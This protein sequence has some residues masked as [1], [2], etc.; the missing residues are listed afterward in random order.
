[1][2]KKSV[3]VF[4]AALRDLGVNQV[5]G[6]CIAFL[7]TWDERPPGL[8][9]LMAVDE[10][11]KDDVTLFLSLLFLDAYCVGEELGTVAQWGLE[12]LL[13]R[14]QQPEVDHSLVM[15][16]KLVDRAWVSVRGSFIA[17]FQGKQRGFDLA[18]R[19]VRVILQTTT[20]G[21]ANRS[22]STDLLPLWLNLAIR[23]NSNSTLL[24]VLPLFYAVDEEE[25]VGP[26][27]ET[28]SS[29]VGGLGLFCR[30]AGVLGAERWK[31]LL[32]KQVERDQ[33]SRPCKMATD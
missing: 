33:L 20:A 15:V 19:I 31:L 16:A 26:L 4:A 10:Q 8:L 28:I 9:E 1:M 32:S 25:P 12:R 7:R 22:I 24:A 17:L 3:S 6:A 18:V 30:V 27:W 2:L 5:E 11:E 21:K 14:D 29:S 13:R 23:S